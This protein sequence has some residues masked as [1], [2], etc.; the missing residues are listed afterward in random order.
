[1]DT[2]ILTKVVAKKIETHLESVAMSAMDEAPE[3]VTGHLILPKD[4][5]QRILGQ[6]VNI[7]KTNLFN[8]YIFHTSFNSWMCGELPHNFL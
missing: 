3:N 6:F 8:C 1:M 2:F 4:T 5:A 7:R